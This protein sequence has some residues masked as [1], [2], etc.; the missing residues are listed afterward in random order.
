[1]TDN[2]AFEKEWSKVEDQ[3]EQIVYP[4]IVSTFKLVA[5]GI[6]LS[7]MSHQLEKQ[8]KQLEAAQ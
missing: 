3:L 7:G 1:M 5:N 4:D 6:F 8:I 2:E